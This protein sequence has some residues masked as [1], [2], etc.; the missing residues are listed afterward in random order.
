MS[1]VKF[2]RSERAAIERIENGE[3]AGKLGG[4]RV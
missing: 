4:Q 2:A 3:L 1:I